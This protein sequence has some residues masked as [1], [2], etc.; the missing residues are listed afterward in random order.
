MRTIEGFTLKQKK[1]KKDGL[2]VVEGKE[3]HKGRVAAGS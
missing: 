3:T 1:L 2:G